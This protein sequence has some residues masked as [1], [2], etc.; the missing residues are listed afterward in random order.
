MVHE[1]MFPVLLH[2]QSENGWWTLITRKSFRI[3]VK[4]SFTNSC[5][6][7]SIKYSP[8]TLVF[9]ATTKN[10]IVIITSIKLFIQHEVNNY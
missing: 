8:G 10:E 7:H 6:S 5:S 4:Y 9:Q 2:G 3:P 1:V